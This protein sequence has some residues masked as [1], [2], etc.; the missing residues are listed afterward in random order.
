MTLIHAGAT[1]AA[2]LLF[3]FAFVRERPLRL[4]ERLDPRTFVSI[5][6]GAAVA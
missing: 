1:L 2:T 6:G 3:V 4:R 5:A